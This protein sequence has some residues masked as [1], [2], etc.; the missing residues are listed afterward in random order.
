MR[1]CPVVELPRNEEKSLLWLMY[2]LKMCVLKCALPFV[3][4]QMAARLCKVSDI[5]SGQVLVGSAPLRP[6]TLFLA[7]RSNKGSRF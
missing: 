4:S 2:L 6:V 3:R 1:L 5:A 7:E